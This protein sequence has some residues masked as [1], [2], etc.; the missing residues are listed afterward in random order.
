[1]N[2]DALNRFFG[3]TPSRVILRLVLLSLL[4][5]LVLSAFNIHPLDIVDW[6]R[7]V[8][9]RIYNMGFQAVEHILGYFL[10]GAAVVIPIWLVARLLNMG[11][12]GAR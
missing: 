9:T 12:P 11:K 3:G 8:V 4:V 5:G 1:M 6:I 10:L 7:S 2:N